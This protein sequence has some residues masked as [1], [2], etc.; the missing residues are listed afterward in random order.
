M[1][2][3]FMASFEHTRTTGPSRRHV[4]RS[5]FPINLPTVTNKQQ[6]EITIL[7]YENK[8]NKDASKIEVFALNTEM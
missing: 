2:T 5:D 1:Y 6:N 8:D 7:K 3:Q 4:K